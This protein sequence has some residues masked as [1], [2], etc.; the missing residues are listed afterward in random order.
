MTGSHPKSRRRGGPGPASQ[1]SAR[2]DLAGSID[3]GPAATAG[4]RGSRAAPP[5]R[6]AGRGPHRADQSPAGRRG[7][8][9]ARIEPI[10]RGGPRSRGR[11]RKPAHRRPQA[12]V[13][14][15]PGRCPQGQGAD[16]PAGTQR[17]LAAGDRQGRAGAGP[18][19]RAQG[20]VERGGAHDE[21]RLAEKQSELADE[22]A[23]L[24]DVLKQLKMAA[25]E[26][27]PELAE[28][29]GRATR[30]NPPEEV[31]ESMRQNAAAIGEGH[32]I[33]A[34]RSADHAAGQLDA[35][36]QDLESVRRAAIA[37]P[38]RPPAGSRETGRRASGTAPLGA[39]ILATGRGR[40]G[41]LRPR[42]P[43]R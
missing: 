40:E 30:A 24:A 1:G 20:G 18:G 16:R 37:A 14:R 3:A 21:R 27:Q 39:T 36:A 33:P 7:S 28:S 32:A 38:A 12:G 26:E 10:D 4:G 43:R 15:A 34:A 8:V 9:G 42:P 25:A 17:D 29:I 6:A 11:R 19:P 41:T 5:A 22:V 13:G 23:A 35:L 31:E 2:P